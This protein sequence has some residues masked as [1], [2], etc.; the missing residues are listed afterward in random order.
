MASQNVGE[1]EED[2]LCSTLSC[3]E[4]QRMTQLEDS[5]SEVQQVHFDANLMQVSRQSH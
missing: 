5:F 3:G 1:E 4:C 2:R